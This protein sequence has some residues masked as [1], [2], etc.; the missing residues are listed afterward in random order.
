M[1]CINLDEVEI[2]LIVSA[3]LRRH[4]ELT[5]EERG[6]ADAQTL[7][8]TDPGIGPNRQRSRARREEVEELIRKLMGEP[9]LV[10]S[11]G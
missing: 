9:F 7:A 4:E 5:R 1:A 8:L 6:H 2:D 11:R 3:L 10:I